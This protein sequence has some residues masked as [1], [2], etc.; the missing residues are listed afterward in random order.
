VDQLLD[1]LF[2]DE[3]RRSTLRAMH[4]DMWRSGV[5]DVN[6]LL[7]SIAE[8]YRWS[9]EADQTPTISI[10]IEEE[11]ERDALGLSDL[12]LVMGEGTELIPPEAFATDLGL[13]SD[14]VVTE[15]PIEIRRHGTAHAYNKGRCRCEECRAWKPTPASDDL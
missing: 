3:T 12:R 7:G 2:E 8:R 1:D 10:E 5:F 4:L 15:S 9:L 11:Y 6:D 13:V 14:P